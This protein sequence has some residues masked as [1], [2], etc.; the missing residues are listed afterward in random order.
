MNIAGE[1][2][3]ESPCALDCVSG[4]E[5]V[6]AGKLGPGVVFQGKAAACPGPGAPTPPTRRHSRTMVSLNT[7]FESFEATDD[8][9][10]S[11]S[12]AEGVAAWT[13]ACSIV[14]EVLMVWAVPCSAGKG[15]GEWKMQRGLWQ[16]YLSLWDA[17]HVPVQTLKWQPMHCIKGTVSMLV[18]GSSLV[19][20]LR[21][22]GRLRFSCVLCR[23]CCSEGVGVSTTL[24]ERM[25]EA[26]CRCFF[27]CCTKERE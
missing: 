12:P 3:D 22:W 11:A 25:N 21:F 8:G 1:V 7:T 24:E 16:Q 6:V 10:P 17:R 14:D 20:R 5:V 19:C 9:V 4:A 18:V 2:E 26:L 15:R 13:S 27:L 23:W